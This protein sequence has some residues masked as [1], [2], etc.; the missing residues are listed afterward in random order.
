M[1]RHPALMWGAL[2]LG[3]IVAAG[4]QE[5]LASKLGAASTDAPVAVYR[6]EVHEVRLTATVSQPNGRAVTDLGRTDFMLFDDGRLVRAFTSFEQTS[7]LPLNLAVL[8]DASESIANDYPFEADAFEVFLRRVMRTEDRTLVMDFS[9]KPELLQASTSDAAALHRAL[10]APGKDGL[11]ALYQAICEAS[12]QLSDREG[13][14]R[15]AIL[16]L[17]DGEDTESP[18][19]L[20]D[21]IEAAQ[22]AGIVIFAISSKRGVERPDGDRILRELAGATGGEFFIPR[23]INDLPA[24]FALIE[25]DLRSEYMMSFHPDE[26][27]G[28]FHKLHLETIR[29]ELKVRARDGYVAPQY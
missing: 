15:R 5:Q 21:A 24:I 27:D 16:I 17:S 4:A 22:H 10:H 11:T 19:G 29:Q 18:V 2:L 7:D 9:T 23:T 8:V 6:S 12:G 20:Q 28:Q 25:G 14:S 26:H 3:T 13:Q 1:K